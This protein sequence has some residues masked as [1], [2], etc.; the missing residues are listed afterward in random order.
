MPM[1]RTLCDSAAP[2]MRRSSHGG[3]GTGHRLG[4]CV[5]RGEASAVLARL[6]PPRTPKLF[7]R[8]TQIARRDPPLERKFPRRNSFAQ[9]LRC[10]AENGGGGRL[11]ARGLDCGETG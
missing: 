3:V 9:P 5:L 11:A 7:C 2:G 8:G 10:A 6:V 1:A 4:D